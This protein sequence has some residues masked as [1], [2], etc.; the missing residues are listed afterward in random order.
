MAERSAR[1]STP[2]ADGRR[3]TVPIPP[4]VEEADRILAIVDETHPVVV[5]AFP[6]SAGRTDV[7]LKSLGPRWRLDDRDNRTA[8]Q[9][10]RWSSSDNPPLRHA[11]NCYPRGLRDQVIRGA[12]F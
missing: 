5:H 3:N 2:Y 8:I 6:T 10:A 7:R 1:R 11:N 9:L 4:H 12:V